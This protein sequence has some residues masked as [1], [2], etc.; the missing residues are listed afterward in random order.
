MPLSGFQM[1]LKPVQVPQSSRLF[2]PLSFILFGYR[3]MSGR[4][5]QIAVNS[6]S[7]RLLKSLKPDLPLEIFVLP[8]NCRRPGSR[9]LHTHTFVDRLADLDFGY[10]L[11]MNNDDMFVPS[12]ILSPVPELNKRITT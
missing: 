10:H 2:L 8:K 11:A 1:D 5:S 9:P 3:V 4:P 6:P 12:D 7:I